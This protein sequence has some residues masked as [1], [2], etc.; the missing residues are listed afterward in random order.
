MRLEDKWLSLGDCPFSDFWGC[1]VPGSK[2]NAIPV[3]LFGRGSQ[4]PAPNEQI[5]AGLALQDNLHGFVVHDFDN[6][7]QRGASFWRSDFWGHGKMK[8]KD[9]DIF[10]FAP[11]EDGKWTMFSVSWK[12]N[13][14]E[15]EYLSFDSYGSLE[16]VFEA[17]GEMIYV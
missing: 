9:A 15:Q 4:L 7:L 3:A 6:A 2:E 1:L 14:D 17:H 8:S 12:E 10:S 13:D 5:H 16:V 11:G